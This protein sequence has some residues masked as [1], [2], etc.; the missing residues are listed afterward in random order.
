MSNKLGKC[1]CCEI[2]AKNTIQV[3]G[4]YRYVVCKGW[5]V[6]KIVILSLTTQT[7]QVGT[8]PGGDEVIMGDTINP[9]QY[10][11]HTQDVLPPGNSSAPLV[12]FF[13]GFIAYAKIN[14]Y[15]LKL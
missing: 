7:I 12:L 4:N 14:I 3:A 9:N 11:S 1:D 5:M 10:Y 13:T 2:V 8:T 6:T 15:T